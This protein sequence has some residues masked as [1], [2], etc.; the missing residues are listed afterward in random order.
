MVEGGCSVPS[1]AVWHLPSLCSPLS[2]SSRWLSHYGACHISMRIQA[3]K[4]LHTSDAVV[5]CHNPRV[6]EEEARGSL[7]LARS[8]S[9]QKA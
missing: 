6:E 8:R 3:E 4:A 5:H 9:R 2:D 7:E 1:D